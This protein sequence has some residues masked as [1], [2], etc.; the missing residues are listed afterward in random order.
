MT[1][2]VRLLMRRGDLD[3]SWMAR[4]N[5]RGMDPADFYADPREI[6]GQQ[7]VRAAR[8]VCWSCVVRTTCLDYAIASPET[9][10]IWGGLNVRER[11][12]EAR[13]RRSRRVSA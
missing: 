8:A 12:A 2:P 9:D 4:G 5:C 3:I 6:G 13:R 7:R 1:Q 10:G 11:R